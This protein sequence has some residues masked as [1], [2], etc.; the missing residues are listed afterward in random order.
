MLSDRDLLRNLSPF[1]G[2][3]TERTQDSFLLERKVHQVMSRRVVSG[4]AD[5]PVKVAMA[6]LLEHKVSCLPVLSAAGA[7]EGI[8]TWRDLLGYALEC[9]VEPG[10]PVRRGAA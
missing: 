9:G 3:S 7:C 5:M 2:R 6:L 10:C 8:V 1:I 4:R